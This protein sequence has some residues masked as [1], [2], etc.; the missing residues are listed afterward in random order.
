MLDPLRE[1]TVGDDRDSVIFLTELSSTSVCLEKQRGSEWQSTEKRARQ[2]YRQK[3][4]QGA[5]MESRG[6]SG[7][8][9]LW[10]PGAGRPAS[11]WPSGS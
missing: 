3:W 2:I 7:P 4:R 5:K 8:L 11:P 1:F 6:Q 10:F 9:F